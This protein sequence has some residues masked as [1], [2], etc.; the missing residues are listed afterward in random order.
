DNMQGTT[1]DERLLMDIYRESN[2]EM[3]SANMPLREW[4]TNNPT[5]RGMVEHDY[6]GYSV[7]EVTSVLG[8]EWEVKEDRLRLKRKP[9]GEGKLTRRSLLSKVQTAFDPLGLL[10]P[11]TIRGRMLVQQT[12]EL[13][14]GWDDPLP[15]TVCQ[16]WDLVNKDLAE[17][18]EF[19]F[20]RSIGC[21]G[22]DYDLHVFC[23]ASSRAYG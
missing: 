20:P 16:E 11:I 15:E 8:L 19:T 5:L 22:R 12:W 13:N 2:Q 14:L 18:H 10:T 21:T 17:L 7:P 9:D 23:D 4:V 1:S 6:T 3:L